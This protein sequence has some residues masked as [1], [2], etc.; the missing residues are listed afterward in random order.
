MPESKGAVTALLAQLYAWRAAVE[1][2]PE[3]WEEAEKYC[4]MIISG[5]PVI[6]PWQDPQ[7]CTVPTH[8]PN[9]RAKY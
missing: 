8:P 3:Y 9:I 7:T 2:K 4:N 5:E 6:T 1:K